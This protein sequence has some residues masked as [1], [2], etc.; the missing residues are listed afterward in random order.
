MSGTRRAGGSERE[1]TGP[2]GA[3]TSQSDVNRGRRLLAAVRPPKPVD[4][5]TAE[6]LQAFADGTAERLRG[7]L[8]GPTPGKTDPPTERLP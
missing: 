4:Q 1:N 8:R 3:G 5:M 7:G 6:E 2:T